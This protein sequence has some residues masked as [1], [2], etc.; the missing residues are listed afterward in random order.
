[1]AAM[2]HG[3]DGGAGWLASRRPSEAAAGG[4]P[5]AA[6]EQICCALRYVPR[7]RDEDARLRFSPAVAGAGHDRCE[8]AGRSA[9]FALWPRRCTAAAKPRR[10]LGLGEASRHTSSARS[11]IQRV[12]VARN[13]SGVRV[14]LVG[15]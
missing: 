2:G 7:S 8:P 1:M 12:S 13:L 6:A 9:P 15:T 4:A 5:V 10:S 3:V 11:V 14:F